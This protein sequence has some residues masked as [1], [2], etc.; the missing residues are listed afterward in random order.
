[1]PGINNPMD[2]RFRDVDHWQGLATPPASADGFCNFVSVPYGIRA[3]T[4]QLIANQ[5]VHNC[6]TIREQISRWAPPSENET[7]KYIANVQAWSGRDDTA[8]INVH[9]YADARPLVDAIIREEGVLK[10]SPMQI[11]QGLRLA[12]VLPMAPVSAM[13][14]AARDPKVIAGSI[15]AGATAAQQ[16]IGS[17]SGVWDSI[18]ASGIDPRVVMGVI[19]IVAG[20]VAL[21]LVVD[22]LQR[23][24]M[25]LA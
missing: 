23:R 13:A 20:A 25:G 10:C 5:D 16:V 22:W 24:R 14:S 7:E 9:L 15:V 4:H 6:H 21:W 12:G 19:G 17:V 11:D 1:M 8:P 3:G 2:V 18:N